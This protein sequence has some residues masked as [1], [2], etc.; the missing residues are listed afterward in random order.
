MVKTHSFGFR[1]VARPKSYTQNSWCGSPLDMITSLAPWVVVVVVVV[2]APGRASHLEMDDFVNGT[3]EKL[4][5]IDDFVYTI[6]FF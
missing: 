4:R 5:V 1:V 6:F 2:V 3:N